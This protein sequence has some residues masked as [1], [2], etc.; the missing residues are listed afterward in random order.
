MKGN[1]NLTL[2]LIADRQVVFNISKI[3]NERKSQLALGFK[4]KNELLCST[5]Q[6]YKMK[7]NH[8]IRKRITRLRELCSTY[9]RYKMK[10]NH[11]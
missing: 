4:S 2:I 6:R 11:N 10:G 9:Q 1:H 8:N 7:G 5:Y 3:Q